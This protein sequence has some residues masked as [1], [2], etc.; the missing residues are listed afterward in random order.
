MDITISYTI[1]NNPN[2]NPDQSRPDP[3]P[4]PKTEQ[5]FGFK[6][7]QPKLQEQKNPQLVRAGGVSRTTFRLF[8]GI[9]GD[10]F[11]SEPSQSI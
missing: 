8:G 7:P 2:P 5:L 6:L 9:S 1:T 11:K 3:R 10:F 4:D